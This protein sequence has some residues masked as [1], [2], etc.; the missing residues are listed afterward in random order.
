MP[1]LS[2]RRC[3]LIFG[4]VACAWWVPVLPA[5]AA[6]T[7]EPAPARVADPL[8]ASRQAIADKRWPAAIAELRRVNATGSADW[9]NLMGY[10]LRK[11]ATPDLDG[12]QRHY[13]AALRIDPSHKG[14]LE[15][16]G[17]L[18]LMKGDLAT[19]EARLALL[20]RLCPAGC[21][22]RADLEKAVARYKAAGNRWQP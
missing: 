18:A 9:N 21:E 3:A 12:A 4:S 10:A 15:Y 22:E 11:Q 8:R 2:F 14:A 7:P 13:D 19:A 6:D 17:E 5:T 20:V 1:S 16:A